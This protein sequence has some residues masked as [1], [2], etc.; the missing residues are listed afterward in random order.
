MMGMRF[1]RRGWIAFCVALM[2]GVNAKCPSA[3][4]AKE[5]DDT[6]LDVK[7]RGADQC[8]YAAAE[9]TA[10]HNDNIK[11]VPVGTIS[12]VVIK[13]KVDAEFNRKI[14]RDHWLS[15]ALD[16]LGL[17]QSISHPTVRDPQST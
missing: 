6:C 2:L 3:A 15:R 9:L 16:R 8:V 17:V 11:A 4:H 14:G 7:R 5:E 10:E 12:D 1:P 13:E